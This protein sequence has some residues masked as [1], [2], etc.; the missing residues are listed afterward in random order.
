MTIPH[1]DRAITSA[2]K[3]LEIRTSG[4]STRQARRRAPRS[5]WSVDSTAFVAGKPRR[6]TAAAG[7][8]S[9]ERR[10]H[11][12]GPIRRAARPT[13]SEPRS[14][15][16]AKPRLTGGDAGFGSRLTWRGAILE[17]AE[18]RCRRRRHGWDHG[19]VPGA[20]CSATERSAWG[21]TSKTRRGRKPKSVYLSRPH[22]GRRALSAGQRLGTIHERHA[23]RS[24]K[25]TC[26]P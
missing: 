23:T 2:E 3:L 5:A 17:P 7:V 24:S 14:Q 15:H 4:A 6:I 25:R 10:V 16:H 18:D 8:V 11:H 13:A 1:G 22:A 26:R 19:G 9:G 12:V 21:P 20:A